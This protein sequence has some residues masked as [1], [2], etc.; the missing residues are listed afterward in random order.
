MTKTLF[1]DD[2]YLKERQTKI[3]KIEG[4]KVL[5]EETIFFPQTSTEPGDVGKINDS[6]VIGLKKENEEIWHIL[7]NPPAFNEGDTVNLQIN[8]NKRYEMMKLHSALHLLA[9]A[10][11]SEFKE[12]A[13][14]GAVKSKSAYL[15]FKNELAG[16]II[17]KALKRANK[18]I[19][20]G[21]KIKTYEDKIRKGFRW[22]QVGNYNPIPCGGLHIKNIKEIGGIILKEKIIE[23]GKQ[24]I[25]I[26]IK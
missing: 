19:Q 4:N 23:N 1:Y 7:N 8:W 18:D 24:K 13:V 14:A 11:D 26:G 2:A 9:G 10:F 5:L 21:L 3:I 16:E 15:V 22:C 12:R 17:E 6:K 20:E 25:V